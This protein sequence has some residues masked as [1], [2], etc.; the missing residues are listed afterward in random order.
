MYEVPDADMMKY[1]ILS[2]LSVVKRGY[3]SIYNQV[4]VV[5]TL[6]LSFSM[7]AYFRLSAMQLPLVVN[8]MHCNCSHWPLQPACFACRYHACLCGTI[9]LFVYF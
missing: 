2:H 1:E 7:A 6:F 8:S 5:H 9:I 4:E 3:D